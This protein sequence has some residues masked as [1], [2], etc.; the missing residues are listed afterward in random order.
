MKDKILSNFW[1]ESTLHSYSIIFFSQDKI[2][3]A[4]LLL[5][6]FFSPFIGIT[7]LLSVIFTHLFLAMIGVDKLQMR[8]G[9]LG[10]NS[11]LVGLSIAYTYQLNAYFVLIFIISILLIVIN[12]IWFKRY[13]EKY[14]LPFF[15]FPYFVSMGVIY[16]AA[17]HF[18]VFQI[19]TAHAFLA[20]ASITNEDNL[21]FQIV[22]SLDN[23][24]IP[25]HLKTFLYT[26]STTFFQ[27]SILGGILIVL[28]LFISSRIT[29]CL[30]VLGFYAAFFFYALMGGDIKDLTH[31]YSGI[32]FIF[33]AIA[34]GGFFLLPNIYSYSFVLALTPVLM[35]ILV[36]LNKLLLSVGI[37]SFSLSFCVLTTATLY[38]LQHRKNHNLLIPT[39]N[40]YYSPEKTLYA[41]LHALT[42]N[43]SHAVY[44]MSLP[45]WGEWMV[46]QGYEGKITHI[47]D[48][49]QAL[50]FIILDDE[51]KSFYG[52]AQT[53]QHFY[54]YNKP[55]LAP[56]DGYIYDIINY[57]EDNNVN[58]VNIEQNWGNTIIM[59][60]LDGTFSQLSHLK[61]DSF[62]V[63]IGDYVTKGTIIATCGNSGRSPEPHIHFQ[64]QNTPIVGAKTKAMPFAYFIERKDNDLTFK[65]NSI[66]EEGTFV[67]NVELVALIAQAFYFLPT[68]KM[69]IVTETQD[70]PIEIKT[71]AYNHLYLHCLTTDAKA[72]FTNDGTLF[73][74]VA[75]QGN[76]KSPLFTFYQACYTVLQGYYPTISIKDNFSSNLFTNFAL[77]T[78][79]DVF[80]PF[81]RFLQVQYQQRYQSIDNEYNPREIIFESQVKKNI[82]GKT[83]LQ[84]NYQVSIKEKNII[85]ILNTKTQEA[86]EIQAV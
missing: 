51:M 40:T 26:L 9:L 1:V 61:K 32:N 46:S 84:T 10:F 68:K 63:L 34:L 77:Q 2:L 69:S 41:H 56:A 23:I 24:E 74:F 58:D 59:N 64:V 18:P 52:T 67:Q 82:F 3:A 53:P 8:E 43:K 55:V 11:L 25:I 80:A 47:G 73:S 20:D 5:V 57:I 85:L 44:N 21:W 78:V 66:P 12:T 86:I 42:W 15:T 16:L 54:S 50:D 14:S 60:H 27:Q 71:N 37:S 17:S 45:F 6:T 13:F 31:Y 7:G 48:W 49:N 33:F 28:G 83:I 79:Q 36:S 4:L 65:I 22:H 38:I 30:A 81:V 39:V 62:K 75:Y 35:F 76:K 29:L 19:N 72:Y 70:F